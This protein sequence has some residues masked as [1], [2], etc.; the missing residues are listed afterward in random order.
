MSHDSFKET[1]NL[2]NNSGG[3]VPKQQQQQLNVLLQN[4]EKSKKVGP[5][6]ELQIKS[7]SSVKVSVVAWAVAGQA[8]SE[9]LWE[10]SHILFVSGNHTRCAASTVRPIAIDCPRSIW[11]KG[12][13]EVG[14]LVKLKNFY[15]KLSIYK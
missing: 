10:C 3:D 11:I 2:I 1:I 13:E 6:R 7:P 14:K 9:A 12:K 15:L 8:A 5:F 4:R